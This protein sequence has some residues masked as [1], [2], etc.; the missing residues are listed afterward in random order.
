MNSKGS[1]CCLF[2]D[3][4]ALANHPNLIQKPSSVVT[5]SSLTVLQSLSSGVT[6]ITVPSSTMNDASLTMLDLSRFRRLKKIVIRSDCFMYV[7]KVKMIGLNELESVVI[8]ENSFTRYKST[9]F[10]SPSSFRNFYLKNCPKLKSLTIG[11]CS[12]SD[13]TVIEIE[14]VD[15]LEEIDI[16]NTYEWSYNFNYASLELK[17]VLIHSK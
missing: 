11:R 16:G 6:E 4:A 3:I 5:V 10:I 13:Y 17:S 7:R 12:F 15:A 2:I 14:N 1:R 8:G 9:S